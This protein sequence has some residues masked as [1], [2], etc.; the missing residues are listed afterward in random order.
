MHTYVCTHVC[1]IYSSNLNV[2]SESF[3]LRAPK[4][5]HI[6][7]KKRRNSLKISQESISNDPLA[8]KPGG[9]GISDK[10]KNDYASIDLDE[11][12]IPANNSVCDYAYAEPKLCTFQEMKHFD[13]NY[14]LTQ[15]T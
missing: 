10:D 1:N 11:T 2:C 8:V 12:S 13:A 4:R 9:A 7:K 5:K 6:V 3:E 15:G 14:N